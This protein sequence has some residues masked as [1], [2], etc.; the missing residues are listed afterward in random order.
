MNSHLQQT[1]EQHRQPLQQP[2]CFSG[3]PSKRGNNSSAT[4]SRA[5]IDYV[6]ELLVSKY[7]EDLNSLLLPMLSFRVAGSGAQ[8]V[9]WISSQPVGKRVLWRFGVDPTKVRFVYPS[10]QHSRYDLA[11]K[12]IAAGNST[13]VFCL[14]SDFTTQQ[15]D[16]LEQLAKIHD[17]STL[18]VTVR[19]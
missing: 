8:W 3:A 12:A 19:D 11:R 2:L 18:L 16:E 6:T 14:D 10:D 5:N 15:R 7:C 9:T 13:S 1:S 17:C 4:T